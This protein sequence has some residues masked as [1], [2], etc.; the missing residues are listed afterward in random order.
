MATWAAI[1]G[2]SNVRSNCWRARKKWHTK[3]DH[4]DNSTNTIS[5]KGTAWDRT[6]PECFNQRLQQ[7][8]LAPTAIAFFWFGLRHPSRIVAFPM[9][10]FVNLEARRMRAVPGGAPCST[11]AGTHPPIARM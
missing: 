3:T 8:G 1:V 4:G 6:H 9:F 5:A 10:Y 7:V 2:E 11:V